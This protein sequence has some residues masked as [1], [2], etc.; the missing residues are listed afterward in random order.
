MNSQPNSQ[1]SGSATADLERMEFAIAKFLRFGALAAGVVLLIASALMIVEARGSDPLAGL[2]VHRSTP[3][4]AAWTGAIAAGN[5]G[6]VFGYV[7][8]FIL[9]SL[10]ILRVALTA[11]LFLRG[12]ERALCAAAAFVL[13]TLA[14]SFALGFAI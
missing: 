7:G 2:D 13:A 10:P 11:V 9:I 12:G 4:Y 8:L 6:L 3:L 5:W 1:P 14:L